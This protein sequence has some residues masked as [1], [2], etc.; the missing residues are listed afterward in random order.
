MEVAKSETG[1]H[2]YS[3][4]N[5][6]RSTGHNWH[7]RKFGRR[8]IGRIYLIPLCKETRY[9]ISEIPEPTEYIDM[10]SVIDAECIYKFL[11]WNYM[12]NNLYPIKSILGFRW[13]IPHLT[14][15]M[16]KKCEDH[17]SLCK[18]DQIP[19]QSA[20]MSKQQDQTFSSFPSSIKSILTFTLR[21]PSS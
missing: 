14:C 10:L 8:S 17:Q 1:N 4:I 16:I 12:T 13:K 7:K 9:S 20:S 11:G 18:C 6:F 2:I 15:L 19:F 5:F 3:P 21:S